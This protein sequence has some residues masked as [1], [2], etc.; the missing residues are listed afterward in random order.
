MIRGLFSAL[1]FLT[2]IPIPESLKS[3]REN[4]MFV[5][6]PLAGLLIGALLSLSYFTA[7]LLFSGPVAA[8]LVTAAGILLTGA[9]HVD[10]LAD[11]ADAFYGRRDKET[12]LRILKDPRIGTMGGI[13]IGLSLLFRCAALVSLPSRLIFFGLPVVA[14]LS[15]T[16]VLIA[17]K[18]L[19]YVRSNDGILAPAS[20][21]PSWLV[22]FA[23]AV[24]CVSAFLLPI[25]TAAALIALWL[26]WR[27]SRNRIGGCTGDVLGATIEI[28]EIV[29]L[30]ALVGVTKTGLVWGGFFRIVE[31]IFAAR[32]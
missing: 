14:M 27:L 16:T 21:V 23:A 13:A 8:V 20:S 6:Y 18:A 10:G 22:A 28:A 24:V 7:Q 12:T 4:G 15:R 29:F 17:M 32:I 30:I 11:C 25:P 19:P 2:V 31:S 9:M 26:F 5:G 1:A 3:R